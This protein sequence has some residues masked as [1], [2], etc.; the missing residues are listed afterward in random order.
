MRHTIYG[1][2]EQPLIQ[3]IVGKVNHIYVYIPYIRLSSMVI[4]TKTTIVIDKK[5]ATLIKKQKLTNLESYDEIIN[6]AIKQLKE[7]KRDDTIRKK[8]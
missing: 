6:R 7:T 1:I 5:T 8:V 4:V 3:D 2:R